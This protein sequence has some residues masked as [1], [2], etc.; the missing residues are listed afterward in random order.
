MR[1][2]QLTLFTRRT[3]VAFR[4]AIKVDLLAVLHEIGEIADFNLRIVELKDLIFKFSERIK[5]KEFVTL[6][7][8]Q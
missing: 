3:I 6:S 4:N 7:L 1:D 8:Q 2:F 5:D